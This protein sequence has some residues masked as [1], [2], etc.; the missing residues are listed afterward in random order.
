MVC[1]NCKKDFKKLN[2]HIL[3]YKNK[4]SDCY[5]YYINKYLVEGNFPWKKN[6]S[7]QYKKCEC[8][9]KDF[10]QLYRHLVQYSKLCYTYYIEKYGREA[11]CPEGTFAKKYCKDCKQ[12]LSD[13]R[14]I[15]CSMCRLENHNVMTDP[16]VSRKMVE[17]VRKTCRERYG[18]DWVMQLD[19]MRENA[20]I[21]TSKL[22]RT[23]GRGTPVVGIMEK[24]CLDFLEY[25]IDYIITR[26]VPMCGYFV[27]GFISNLNLVI[28]FDEKLHEK[29]EVK[30][31]DLFR[32][33]NIIKSKNYSFF[34]IKEKNWLNNK[35]S[36]LTKLN[37]I[38]D[39][40]SYRQF[41]MC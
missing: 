19:H 26:Q 5:N 12:L 20:R 41:E 22:V 14:A 25:N 9:N 29:D 32:Q 3:Q 27:D 4:N 36:I 33:N 7:I 10:K 40:D 31:K 21:R 37:F 24:K 28:E 13:H 8:C 17:S 15:Y 39:N 6:P 2:L 38:I 30:E 18:V 1:E 11:D 34:R 16:V 23:Y 35:N